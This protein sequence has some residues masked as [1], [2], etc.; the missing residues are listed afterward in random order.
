[1]ERRPVLLQVA[2]DALELEGRG[3]VRLDDVLQARVDL[4]DLCEDLLRLRLLRRDA[5]WLCG[6]R[7]GSEQN[8]CQADDG[9]ICLSLQ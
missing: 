7:P 9:C 3:V 5:R 8:R 1:V 4:L 2:V 6:R